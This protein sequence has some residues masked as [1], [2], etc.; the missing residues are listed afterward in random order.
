MMSGPP[1]LLGR[2]VCRLICDQCG[3]SCR[4]FDQ[5]TPIQTPSLS[6]DGVLIRGSGM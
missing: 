2:G 1:H 4:G 3:S 6:G 5:S